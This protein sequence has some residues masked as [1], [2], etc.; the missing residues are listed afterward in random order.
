MLI[1][2]DDISNDVHTLSTCFSKFVYIRTCFCFA[3]MGRN[4]TA[5]S[6]GSASGGLE[7]EFKSQSALKLSILFPPRGCQNTPE[8]LLAGSVK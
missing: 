5:Q 8:S 2:G 3:L 1:G 6:M 7:V 4:L